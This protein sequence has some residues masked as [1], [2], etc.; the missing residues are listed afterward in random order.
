MAKLNA[1]LHDSQMSG[2]DRQ[3]IKQLR[4]YQSSQQKGP[5]SKD[6]AAMQHNIVLINL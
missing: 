5:V 1:M 2:G 4:P 3:S 6:Y